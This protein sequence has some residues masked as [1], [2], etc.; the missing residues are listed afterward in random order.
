V[1]KSAEDEKSGGAK[2][3]PNISTHKNRK[4]H[5]PSWPENQEMSTIKIKA[6]EEDPFEPDSMHV[7]ATGIFNK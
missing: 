4:W 3:P 7:R 6:V 2:E 1:K 5:A